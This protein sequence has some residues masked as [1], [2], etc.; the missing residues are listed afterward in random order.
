MKYISDLKEGERVIEFYLC[1]EKQQLTTK[2]NK[3][4]MKLTL[5]D[6][7]GS[8]TGMIWEIG[9]L[10]DDFSKGDIIKV[11]GKVQSYQDSKQLVIQKVRRATEKDEI[12]IRDFYHTSRV[13]TDDLY[14]K[15]IGM[16]EQI[17]DEALRRLVYYF[18]RDNAQI[19]NKLKS[20]P[21]AKNIHHSYVGGL[22]E[23][24]VSVAQ[25]AASFKDIYPQ[26]DLDLLI[27]GGLLHDIGK[28]TELEPFPS[29]EYSDMGRLLGHIT[30]GYQMVFEQ[31]SKIADLS[32][33]KLTILSHMILS[34]HGKLEFASP[35]VPATMEAMA[36]NLADLSD[37]QLKLMEDAIRLDNSDGH[38]TGYNRA[39]E[40]YIYKPGDEA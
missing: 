29:G 18:Y 22:L 1:K 17:R 27:A 12:N 26:L 37:S 40:R 35:V 21:A 15:A 39:L 7:T 31:G 11:D 28:L 36:L 32:E 25:I 23:H 4:F 30:I 34:H 5:E 33:K 13:S 8:I 14:N 2:T 38:W 3:D 16:I 24:S 19:S 20:H 9:V 6:K 10:I